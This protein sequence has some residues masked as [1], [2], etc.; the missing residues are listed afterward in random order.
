MT[1]LHLPTKEITPIAGKMLML[2]QQARH[3][4][5]PEARVFLFGLAKTYSR[6]AHRQQVEARQRREAA[7]AWAEIAQ[8]DH[9]K[10]RVHY[11]DVVSG[12][13]PKPEAKKTEP[14]AKRAARLLDM[15]A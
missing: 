9:G 1:T 10:R 8:E 12:V 13:A 2:L 5:D 14:S 3:E 11:I 15:W 7:L 6:R 4:D